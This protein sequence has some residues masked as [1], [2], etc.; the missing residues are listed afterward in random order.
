MIAATTMVMRRAFSVAAARAAIG[1]ATRAQPAVVRSVPAAADL[2]KPSQLPASLPALASNEQAHA[3]DQK[4]A[5]ILLRQLN[6][7]MP[8]LRAYEHSAW[9]WGSLSLLAATN[10]IDSMPH[11]MP[12]FSLA[13]AIGASTGAVA[14]L[15]G[16]AAIAADIK[17]G[18]DLLQSLGTHDVR[19][20][21]P[22]GL[23]MRLRIDGV[24]CP[25][26]RK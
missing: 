6:A 10:A 16:R 22:T 7:D 14:A 8:V 15:A 17:N 26:Y 1:S 24:D 18:V 2:V 25:A 11:V 13:V 5:E 3:A 12:W 23:R 21:N 4:I 19:L 9:G 20:S